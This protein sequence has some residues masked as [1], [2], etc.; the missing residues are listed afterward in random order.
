M[1]AASQSR[2][3]T[4]YRV[5]AQSVEA[6]SCAHGCACRFGGTP[7][8]GRCEL[9]IGYDIQEGRFGSVDLKGV[10]AVIAGRYPNAIHEGR[11]HIVLFVDHGATPE[12]MDAVAAIVS[13]EVG[14]M[15]WEVLAGTIEKFEGPLAR[16]IDLSAAGRR[17][18][19]RIPGELEL[20]T[21]PLSNPVAGEDGEVRI[22][23]QNGFFRN[24]GLVVTSSTMRVD[25]EPIR[26][27]WPGRYAATAEVTWSNAG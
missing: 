14:G 23:S 21:T 25:R 22:V 13:G 7:D 4:A 8:E 27:A 18:H 24:D 11:G 20:A 12:Q 5:R 10:R 15:P 6:C 2:P 3:R 17:A 9:I 26:M 19:I 16:P 1:T